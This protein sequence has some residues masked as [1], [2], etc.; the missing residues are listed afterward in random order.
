M[1]GHQASLDDRGVDTWS[2]DLGHPQLDA[3][4]IDKDESPD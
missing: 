2:L 1:I 4:I 3:T